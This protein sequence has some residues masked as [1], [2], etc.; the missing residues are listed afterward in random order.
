MNSQRGGMGKRIEK[1]INFAMRAVTSIL[2]FFGFFFLYNCFLP[3]VS[4]VFL[5]GCAL[6]ICFIELPILFPVRSFW[7]R[8][9]SSVLFLSLFIPLVLINNTPALHNL[10][11]VVFIMAFSSDSGGYIVGNLCGKHYFAPTI[12]PKKTVEGVVGSFF[13]VL[14]ILTWYT[15][16]P[17]SSI[18]GFSFIVAILATSGDLFESYLKRKAGVK[19][20]SALVPGHG[21][22]LDRFDSI[23]PVGI[24]CYIFSKQIIELLNL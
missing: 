22:L 23:L 11:P 4:T 16:V 5:L 9:C 13:C 1:Q 10:F 12:S 24:F 20:A 7:Y 14:L 18:A 3:I 21:G 8:L 2:G 6:V 19:D 17:A 15:A